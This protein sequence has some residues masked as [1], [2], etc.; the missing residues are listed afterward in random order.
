MAPSRI[1]TLAREIEANTA[2]LDKYFEE[3]GIP[4]PSFEE[5]AQMMYMLPPELALAQEALSAALD[6][7]WWLNQGP[8]QT[9]VAKSVSTNL[10][11]FLET[12]TSLVCDIRWF[13]VH[14]QIQHS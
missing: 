4:P 8:I 9:I 2:K 11:W 14:P 7:L 5:D 13:E 6:E 3:N 10:A 1:L 12:L